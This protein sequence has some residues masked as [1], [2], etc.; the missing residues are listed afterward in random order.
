MSKSAGTNLLFHAEKF[1][2]RPIKLKDEVTPFSEIWPIDARNLAIDS[3][4]AYGSVSEHGV[5][6][7]AQQRGSAGIF[8]QHLN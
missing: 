7:H 6:S 5:D 3:E 4:V 8:D 1:I 2:P